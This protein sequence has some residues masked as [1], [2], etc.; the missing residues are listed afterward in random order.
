MVVS[1]ATPVTMESRTGYPALPAGVPGIAG[2]G[3]MCSGRRVYPWPQKAVSV[4]TPD[5]WGSDT[6]YYPLCL[7]LYTPGTTGNI[8]GH[9]GL[10]PVWPEGW[11]DGAPPRPRS[12]TPGYLLPHHLLPL[13]GTGMQDSVLLE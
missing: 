1:V 12:H 2:P 7:S 4:A 6:G 5:T 8:P 10:C 11:G 9:R 3:I 13:A